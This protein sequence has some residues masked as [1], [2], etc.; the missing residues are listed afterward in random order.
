MSKREAIKLGN[1]LTQ[2]IAEIDEFKGRWQLLGKLA[3]KQLNMFKQVATIESVGSSTRI[4]G[5]I[6]SDRQVE[7][8]LFGAKAYSF[9]SREEQEVAGY[10][11]VMEEIFE[12]WEHIPFTEN[13]IKQLHVMLLAESDKDQWHRGQYKKFQSYVEKLDAFSRF[14]IIRSYARVGIV[15]GANNG[16]KNSA[17]IACYCNMHCRVFGDS[18]ISRW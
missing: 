5:A 6:L 12:S 11:R 3:P 2:L 13:Y 15:G 9:V 7:K 18:S 1:T 8:L 17:S 10:A 4:E 14:D 16:R